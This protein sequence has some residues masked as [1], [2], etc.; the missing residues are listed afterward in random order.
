MSKSTTR[1]QIEDMQLYDP[2]VHISP[3]KFAALLLAVLDLAEAVELSDFM[4]GSSFL[5]KSQGPFLY[6]GLPVYH[7]TIE[8][9]GNKYLVFCTIH[10]GTAGN[11]GSNYITYVQ[12]ENGSFQFYQSYTSSTVTDW[13]K[14][15][16]SQAIATSTYPGQMSA[17]LFKRLNAVYNFCVAQGMSHVDS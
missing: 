10:A 5:P 13:I 9:S 11:L 15:T 1:E 17:L 14:R 8:H 4:K 7:R 2:C 3:A 16:M 6:N 12:R